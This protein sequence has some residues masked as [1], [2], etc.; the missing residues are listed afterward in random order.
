MPPKRTLARS[1]CRV[2]L[3]D[4]HPI[5][6]RG[7]QLLLG[8]EP[9]LMVCGEADNGP[10]AL[11]K[12]LSLKPDVVIV[13]LSLKG[14]NGL[15]LIKQLRAQALKVK[16]LV[17]TMRG[18]GIYAE[19]ALRAGADGYITKEEGTEKAIEAIRVLMEGKRYLSGGVAEKM[20]DNLAGRSSG[21]ESAAETLSDRELEVLELIGNGLGSREIAEKLH[22][23][24][25]TIESHREHIKTKLGL[26]RASELVSY[27]FNW[28]HGEN[29]GP[30]GSP[31]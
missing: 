24:I 11:Q 21:A 25:K 13:D 27:A 29:T 15:E 7:F 18:E 6:R 30:K 23:S 2:F 17:F 22:L 9:D 4:D 19:R 10:A 20:M 1:K 31:Q 28:F 5:V 14:S 12:I 26:Q 3:V 16:L 8:M